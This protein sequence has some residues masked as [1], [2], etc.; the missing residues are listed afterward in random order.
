[1][2][3]PLADLAEPEAAALA[4]TIRGQRW[5]RVSALYGML[6]H[7]PAI[8]E[9]WVGLGS[10]VRRRTSL[11]DRTRELVICAIAAVCGQSYE[12]ESHAALARRAGATPDELAHVLDRD[13]CPT[14]SDR[15]RL[16]LDLAVATANDQVTDAAFH[17]AAEV[18][19]PP[20]LVEVVATAAY[21]VGTAQFLSAFGIEAGA[22]NLVDPEE[23]P[24][25]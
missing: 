24:P 14:F 21:Y 1:M 12:W 20:E 13:A 5:G 9:G 18:L 6:L 4:R 7:H 10:A 15:E 2:R 19:A 22:P 11:D 16:V 8:A 17:R 25:A 3:Q 23:T